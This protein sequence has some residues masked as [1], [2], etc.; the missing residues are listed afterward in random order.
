MDA[1]DAFKGTKQEL[2]S[3]IFAHWFFTIKIIS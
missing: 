3:H 1:H 2:F